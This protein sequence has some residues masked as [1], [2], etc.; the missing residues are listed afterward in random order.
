L[1][2][3]WVA[4]GNAKLPGSG[5]SAFFLQNRRRG[6]PFLQFRPCFRRASKTHLGGDLGYNA[7]LRLLSM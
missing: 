3:V 4:C 2:L 5:W 6:V 1:P 7:R